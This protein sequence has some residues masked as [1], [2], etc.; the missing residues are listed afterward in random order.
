MTRMGVLGST[1]SLPCLFFDFLVFKISLD[2]KIDNMLSLSSIKLL[3]QSLIKFKPKNVKKIKTSP[4][5]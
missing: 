5:P 2:K 4:V 1:P 3:S